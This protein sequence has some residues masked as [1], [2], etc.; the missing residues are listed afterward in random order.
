[1]QLTEIINKLT[2]ILSKNG[3]CEVLVNHIDDTQVP[4]IDIYVEDSTVYLDD[5]TMNGY[6]L[7]NRYRDKNYLIPIGHNDYKLVLQHN[8]GLRIGH[9]DDKSICFVD[10]SGGPMLNVGDKLPDLGTIT[11][12]YTGLEGVILTIE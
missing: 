4:L 2:E 5:A 3:D 6:K 8:L 9:N 12:I 10:P 1:M 7:S 11:K